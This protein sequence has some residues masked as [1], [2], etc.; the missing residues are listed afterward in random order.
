M[1]QML[2]AAGF[3][4]AGRFPSFEADE[5][6]EAPTADFLE[7]MKGGAVKLIDP[8]RIILPSGHAYRFIFMKR[9]RRQQAFSTVKFFD[10]VGI[11][12]MKSVSLQQI[13]DLQVQLREDE[14]KAKEML[15]KHGYEMITV[16][17]E[18]LVDRS[19]STISTITKFL[20]LAGDSVQ[21]DM[22]NCI[23]E[24]ESSCLAYMLEAELMAVAEPETGGI[25]A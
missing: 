6:L 1:M 14:A 4:C 9:S 2:A 15:G 5:M 20:Q 23:V 16:R 3:N 17:F 25:E 7:S 10:A 8:H 21:V 18:D 24:R 11:C 19:E 22:L 13:I 12:P